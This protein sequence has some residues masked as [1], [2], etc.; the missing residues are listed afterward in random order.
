MR[1]GAERE[2]S[3]GE[4]CEALHVAS[5]YQD[6]Y[7]IPTETAG[8]CHGFLKILRRVAWPTESTPLSI[9]ANT[10]SSATTSNRTRLLAIRMAA[11]PINAN[12]KM[13]SFVI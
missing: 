12:T 2:L 5:F 4:Y 8:F 3:D 10:T 6:R 9:S 1:P 7:G 11:T 13:A